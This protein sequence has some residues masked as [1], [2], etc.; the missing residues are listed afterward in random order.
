ME[1]ADNLPRLQLPLFYHQPLRTSLEKAGSFYKGT[2]NVFV[3]DHATKFDISVYPLYMRTGGPWPP[4]KDE[5][6]VS[7]GHMGKAVKPTDAQ[8]AKEGSGAQCL[9][10][11][12]RRLL[13]F[14]MARSHAK[15]F[16]SITDVADEVFAERAKYCIPMSSSKHNKL[17]HGEALY[18]VAFG[19]MTQFKPSLRFLADY[20]DL[21]DIKLH[22]RDP[23]W[24]W[25]II[26][27]MS[28]FWQ[29][30]NDFEGGWQLGAQL[31]AKDNHR[32]QFHV[33]APRVDTSGC[34]ARSSSRDYDTPEDSAD[35][36]VRLHPCAK[37]FLLFRCQALRGKL[38]PECT[39]GHRIPGPR[40]KVKQAVPEAVKTFSFTS[41][42][43]SWQ[44]M[45]GVSQRSKVS[46][47]RKDV[48][49]DIDARFSTEGPGGART[50]FDGYCGVQI[51]HPGVTTQFDKTPL[52]TCRRDALHP[53]VD[54]VHR[55]A[56]RRLPDG[57]LQV[58]AHIPGNVVLTIYGFNCLHWDKPVI[59]NAPIHALRKARSTQDYQRGFRGVVNSSVISAVQT[60]IQSELGKPDDLDEHQTI[61]LIDEMHAACADGVVTEAR[62]ADV[63]RSRWETILSADGKALPLSQSEPGRDGVS[64]EAVPPDCGHVR[65]RRCGKRV[66]VDS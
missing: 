14:L 12:G 18:E 39:A 46:Q 35:A 49:S 44:T 10:K 23:D 34:P 11:R 42:E 59:V 5:L 58:G 52:E 43:L 15:K 53:S 32:M 37:C 50:Y 31:A 36:H 61:T 47:G 19:A 64:M 56:Y 65:I 26:D 60:A 62:L 7:W 4:P 40:A 48:G 6:K 63:L 20:P 30:E 2:I 66:P 28:K 51:S 33:M 54:A 57:S 22:T 25:P 17:Y 9:H 55:L 3:N 29:R 45:K 27:H 21:P 24:I 8:L 16:K 38:C 41:L 1:D 13:R